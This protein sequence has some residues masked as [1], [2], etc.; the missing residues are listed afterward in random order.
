MDPNAN[1][2]EIRSLAKSV[3]A[4]WEAGLDI[5]QG[6]AAELVS[7]VQDLDEWITRGGFLPQ[8]WERK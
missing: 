3:Y 1:L 4:Q 6:N 8:D 5:N 2:K 7:L